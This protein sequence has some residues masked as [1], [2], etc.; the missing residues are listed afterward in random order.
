MHR[1]VLSEAGECMLD[2]RVARAHIGVPAQQ[3]GED[4][5]RV[6]IT[7]ERLARVSS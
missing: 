5:E 7:L 3:V 6:T 1:N 2:R 4:L